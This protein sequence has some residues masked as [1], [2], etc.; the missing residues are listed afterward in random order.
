MGDNGGV[1]TKL[2]FIALIFEVIC[3]LFFQHFGI[4]YTGSLDINGVSK[5]STTPLSVFEWL[6]SASSFNV[7]PDTIRIVSPLTGLTTNVDTLQIPFWICLLFNFLDI[8]IIL[9]LIQ[10]SLRITEVFMP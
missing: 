10:F 4:G 9:G 2:F 8:F 3:T 1:V 7:V 5:I 6:L